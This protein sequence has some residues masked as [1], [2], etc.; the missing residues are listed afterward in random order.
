MSLAEDLQC[1]DS[2]LFALK[3]TIKLMLVHNILCLNYLS[4]VKEHMNTGVNLPGAML[5]DENLEPVENTSTRELPESSI[6]DVGSLNSSSRSISFNR[7][8]DDML[9]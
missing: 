3:V 1:S 5:F 9:E 6:T 2:V 7:S 4:S 8:S